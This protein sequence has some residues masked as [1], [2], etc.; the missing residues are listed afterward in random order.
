M[1]V[2]VQLIVG[3]MVV[4]LL[5]AAAELNLLVKMLEVEEVVMV[6]VEGLLL[7]EVVEVVVYQVQALVVHQMQARDNQTQV[8]Q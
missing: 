2:V 6:M 3:E 4:G 1:V 8:E 5:K 7:E